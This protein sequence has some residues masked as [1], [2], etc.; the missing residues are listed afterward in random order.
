MDVFAHHH[1]HYHHHHQAYQHV[2]NTQSTLTCQLIKERH[3]VHSYTQPKNVTSRR[4]KGKVGYIMLTPPTPNVRVSRQVSPPESPGAGHVKRSGSL[5]PVLCREASCPGPVMT[6]PGDAIPDRHIPRRR[7]VI[8]LCKSRSEAR[9]MGLVN[10]K[11]CT[12]GP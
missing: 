9:R 5:A 6:P 7:S 8:W 10:H 12:G 1:H 2:P 4:A 11:A 3:Q